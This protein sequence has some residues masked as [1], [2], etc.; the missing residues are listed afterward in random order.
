MEIR[1]A[2]LAAV[3]ALGLAA[4]WL[5]W[6][7]RLPSILLLL[8]FGFAFGGLG[9]LIAEQWS[10]AAWVQ[11]IAGDDGIFDPDHLIGR[12]LLF[13]FVSLS[14]AVILFEGGLTL[15]L[16]ELTS[17]GPSVFRL[18]T[19]GA[20]VTWILVSL[21][22]YFA[23]GF[24]PGLAAL[25]GGILVVTGPTVIG[26]LLRHIRP[27]G[28]VASVAKWEGIVIDPIGAVLAVLV[29]EVITAGSVEAATSTAVGGLVMT[30]V[31]GGLT[32]LAGAVVVILFL[33]RYLVPDYLHNLF[34]L[35][36]V[37]SA[38]AV[39]NLIQHESGLVAVTL[40]G[41]ILANQKYV[42]IGHIMEFKEN[43]QVLLISA[44]FIILAARLR[45]DDLLALGWGGLVFLAVVLFVVRPLAVFLCM[46]GSSTNW[47]E[48]L[49]LSFMAPRGIVAAAVASV[50]TLQLIDPHHNVPAEIAAQAAL[51]GPLTFLVII[52][53]VVFYGLTAGPVARWL[54]LA[55]ANPQGVLIA[56]AEPWVQPIAAALQQSGIHVV[57]VDTN[58]EN[59]S[60][61]RMSDLTAYCASVVSEYVVEE[62]DLSGIGHMMALTP[63]DSVN[64]LAVREFAH[65]L[66]RSNVYHLASRDAGS[67]RRASV[68]QSMMGR[69]L[70]G[71]KITRDEIYGRV[72]VGHE[73]RRTKLT[74]EF[75]YGSFRE[76]YGENA[77]VLFLITKSGRLEIGT[78]DDPLQPQS[79]DTLISLVKPAEGT[80]TEKRRKEK[81]E[82]KKAVESRP[83][84]ESRT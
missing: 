54:N 36:T 61:A 48:R 77:L 60:R 78:V 42:T 62:L 53:S 4:Q 66:G 12:E 84:G 20:L 44:L 63:N 70:W 72:S 76:M 1:L 56:G 31:A 34:I 15:K 38:F 57:L 9:E 58:Y 7:F 55:I 51:L 71:Q 74:E 24:D 82:K 26:P 17:S 40:L 47:R 14:V 46:F 83:N 5:A 81:K 27:T 41:V 16:G 39:S 3:V 8:A 28:R 37:L 2:F 80:G 35:A 67:S 65:R 73:I 21:A 32:G 59:C 68:S 75:T 22:A 11:E 30:I 33:K 64:A 10:D 18:V 69:T 19:G 45:M 13:P 25:A 29:F 52:G 6:R 23:L 43:L 50:F 49:F 79:G